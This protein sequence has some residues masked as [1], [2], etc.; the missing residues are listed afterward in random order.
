MAKPT[1]YITRN[2]PEK[3]E[4]LL[5][6]AGYDVQVNQHP[7]ALKPEELAKAASDCDAMIC[8]LSDKITKE[9]MDAAP[10]CRMYANYAVGYDNMDVA[11]ATAKDVRL[12]NTP[13]VLSIATAEMAWSLIFAAARRLGEGERMMRNGDFHGWEP[14]MLVGSEITGKTL[15]IIG[16]GRIGT[17]M[18][19][20]AQGFAMRILYTKNSGTNGE[21]DAIGG[22]RVDLDELLRESDIV[23]I[24]APLTASTR[25]MIGAAQ[26]PLMKPTAILVNTGRGPVIDEAALAI[27]LAEKTIAAAGLDVYE[28][29]PAVES[30]LLKLDNV[31]LAPHLGS[32]TIEARTQMAE[33]A[34]RNVIDFLSGKTPRTCI[35]PPKTT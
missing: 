3:G 5:K 33:L 35:N 17:A 18:G 34:A 11:A 22:R 29:E 4:H 1:V 8:L 24:H 7:R 23:S 10:R 20:M 32:A 25:H 31:I 28:R 15:G 14:L 2:L 26:F 13:D 19:R 16:A 12:S 21:L 30:G 9:L 6:Q 27:A